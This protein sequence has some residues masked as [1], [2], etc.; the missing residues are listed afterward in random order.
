MGN[1]N[2]WYQSTSDTKQFNT[3][4]CNL[5]LGRFLV[6][7]HV[8]NTHGFHSQLETQ[9]WKRQ[10]FSR[11]PGK[12]EGKLPFKCKSRVAIPVFQGLTVRHKCIGK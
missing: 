2:S 6:S 12:S 8:F 4:L 5:N 10:K 7:F 11:N 3:M 1:A 9:L